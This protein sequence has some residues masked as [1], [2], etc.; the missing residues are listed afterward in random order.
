MHKKTQENYLK[1][2]ARLTGKKGKVR[3][4]DLANALSVTKPTVTNALHQLEEDGCI[5]SDKEN[6]IR[7]TDKGR[8]IA[9]KTLERHRTFKTILTRLGVD[10]DTAD[11]D[12]CALEHCVSDES[13]AAFVRLMEKVTEGEDDV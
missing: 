1:T 5:I 7:L 8:N 4:I 12:A 10:E 13:Y 9:V 3:N 11:R 6:G 2:I